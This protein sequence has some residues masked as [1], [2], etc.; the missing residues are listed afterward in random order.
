MN[1]CRVPVVH[2]L[3]QLAGARGDWSNNSPGMGSAQGASGYVSLLP[4]PMNW[5]L[6]SDMP[7]GVLGHELHAIWCRRGTWDEVVTFASRI[8]YSL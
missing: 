3:A 7:S 1:C 5:Q 6:N 4:H 8:Q 2:F